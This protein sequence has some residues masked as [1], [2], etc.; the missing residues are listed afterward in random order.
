[1]ENLQDSK[2]IRKSLKVLGLTRK[3]ISTAMKC[4]CYFSHLAH[5][6]SNFLQPFKKMKI[7]KTSF[8]N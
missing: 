3:K 5:H 7:D 4:T 8:K 1:M 2:Q 6:F